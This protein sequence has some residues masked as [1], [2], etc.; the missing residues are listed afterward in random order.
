MSPQTKEEEDLVRDLNL[1]KASPLIL[2]SRLKTKC[3][4]WTITTFVWYEHCERKYI[5]FFAMEHSLIYCV[6]IQGLIEKLETVY[7]PSDWCLSIDASKSSL[8]AVLFCNR[9]QFASIPF[10]HLTCM[11]ES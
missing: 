11:E 7:N 6:D 5:C 8:K 1:P 10:A 4:I 3:M 2:C 9:N